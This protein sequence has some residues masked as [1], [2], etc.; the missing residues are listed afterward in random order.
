M[1]ISLHKTIFLPL[2]FFFISPK[3]INKNIPLI[4]KFF[5][6]RKILVCREISKFY[7]EYIRCNVEELEILKIK[8]KG[9]LTIVISEKIIN[10]NTSNNLDES[11]KKNIREMI[12]TESVKD[13]V[14]LINKKK[15]I[16]KKY[17][18]DYCL[19]IKKE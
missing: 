1:V 5:Y 17:I 3:K 18:Y 14:S 9:E 2:K 12:K 19:K 10:K 16:P 15:N 11:D 7:E 8:P 4:K 13:I 6:K